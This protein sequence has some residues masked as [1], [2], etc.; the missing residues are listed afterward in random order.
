MLAAV[1]MFAVAASALAESQS[2]IRC[3]CM[4]DQ[5]QCFIQYGDEGKAVQKIVDILIEKKYLPKG[6]PGGLFSAD[7][8]KAVMEFQ[9]DHDLEA[10]GM[11]DDPTLTLLLWGMTPEQLDREKPETVFVCR[12]VYIPTDGGK[13]RHLDDTCSR[14]S[15]PR[16]VSERNAER[17]GFDLCK[18]CGH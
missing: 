13:K 7:V 4:T 10:T 6:T 17:L 12:T 11:M 16:K 5:C 9:R 3:D 15:D 18:R 8:E 2:H 14:M 1:M